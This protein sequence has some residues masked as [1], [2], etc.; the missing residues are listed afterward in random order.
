MPIIC[1]QQLPAGQ[2]AEEGELELDEDTA[3]DVLTEPS[4]KWKRIAEVIRERGEDGFFHDKCWGLA[5][6]AQQKSQTLSVI[7]QWLLKAFHALKH[8]G[9]LPDLVSD[10]EE[11][12]EA[13]E[14]LDPADE[15]PD[16]A[17]TPREAP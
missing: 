4:D 8:I 13:D 1:N 16:P 3:F 10:G 7:E 14:P 5:D 17:E 6:D 2:Q 9:E 12:D 11:G 15:P